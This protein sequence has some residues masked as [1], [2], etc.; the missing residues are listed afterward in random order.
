MANRTDSKNYPHRLEVRL[1]KR[2]WA[3]FEKAAEEW[4]GTVSDWARMLLRTATSRG[5]RELN[6]AAAR[7]EATPL[8][9][10]ARGACGFCQAAGAQVGSHHM[11]ACPRWAAYRG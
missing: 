4:G 9:E 2:D 6:E 10:V 11:E 8:P 1:T 7:D 5:Q 3:G